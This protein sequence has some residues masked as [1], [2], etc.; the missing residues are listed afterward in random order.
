MRTVRRW[1]KQ[2][3]GSVTGKRDD[4]LAQE[5]ESHLEMH[6]AENIRAGMTP[7]EARRRAHA[8]LGGIEA[9]KESVRDQRGMEW[10]DSSFLDIKYAVRTLRRNPGFATT[11]ILSLALGLGTSL[12]VFT[13]ADNL[14]V[15]PLPHPDAQQLVIVWEG[16]PHRGLTRNVVSPGNYLDWKAQSDVFEGMAGCQQTRSILA[17]GERVEE[18]G[19]QRVTADFFDVLRSRPYRGRFFTAAEDLASR[20]TDSV[21]VISH[22]FWQSWFGGD[23][24]VIGRRVQVNSV[25]RTIIGVMPPGFYFRDR[26]VDVWEP[27][28]LN[29]AQN[30]RKSQGR[31]MNVIARLKDSVPISQ[32]Q[33]E[34]NV[35]GTRLA[36][37]YPEF[38]KGWAIELE[39]LR[40]SLTGSVKPSLLVLLGAVGLLLA[41]ACANIANLLLARYL[42]RQREIAVRAS[43]GAA[44]SRVVRQLLTESVLLSLAGGAAGVLLARGIVKVLLVLAPESIIRAAD[45]QVDLRIY[46]VAVA[47][48]V[49]TGIVF[50]LA[51]GLVAAR[52]D[53]TFS[54]RTD[55]RT[56]TGKGGHLRLWLVGAEIAMTVVLLVGALLLFQ[57]LTGLQSIRSGLDPSNVLT[58]VV[59]L[60]SGRYQE[61]PKRTQFFA[62]TIEELRNLPGVQQASAVSYPPFSGPGAGTWIRFENAPAAKPGEELS[63]LVRVVMPEYFKTLGVPLQRGRDFTAAD[64]TPASPHRFIVNEAFVHAYVKDHA[65]LGKRISV[66]MESDNPFGEIVGVVGNIRE[67]SVEQEPRP[68]V[69]YPHAKL[70]MSGMTLLA[71]T[72]AKPSALASAAA[73]VVRKVDAAQPVS[74]VRTMEEILGQDYARQRFSAV[75]LIFFSIAALVVAAIGIYGVIGHA[76]SQRTREIGLRVALGAPPRQIAGMV[77]ASGAKVIVA[78]IIAGIAGS[79]ALTGLVRN[80]LYGVGPRDPFTFGMVIATMVLIAGIAVWL[81]AR[82]A[83]RLSP[84][85]ALRTE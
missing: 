29:P 50:G 31:W 20:N 57:S 35:I 60:P 39:T 1:W 55:S 17:A 52:T 22:R 26:T 6:T 70:G 8:Q 67:W 34:M 72:A 41:V 13:V 64:N 5:I 71:K 53:L 2:L 30:Y 47:L 43:L 24:S 61:V 85:D 83:L 81:P 9:V 11:A 48:S 12:A 3:A 15:R 44:R 42:T 45:V 19:V 33:A 84:M 36:S 46:V 75:L 4:D 23:E 7:G 63:A 58:F 10:L 49:V 32:A 68:T 65:P 74:E 21:L 69:Y 28:G 16:N 76:V 54:L 56:S 38:D 40:D 82:R 27:L 25:A 78:G 79:L 73:D 80:L 62:R 51:P 37:A 66:L 18:I 77:A 14:L 59:N